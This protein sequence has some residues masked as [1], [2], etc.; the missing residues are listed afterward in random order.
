MADAL[1]GSPLLVRVL[2]VFHHQARRPWESEFELARRWLT[3]SELGCRF[4]EHLQSEAV[5]LEMAANRLNVSGD[6]ELR[7]IGR[8]LVGMADRMRTIATGADGRS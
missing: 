4:V 2:G 5:L 1:D 3:Q 6:E 8:E 7:E